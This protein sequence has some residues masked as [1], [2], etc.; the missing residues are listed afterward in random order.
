MSAAEVAELVEH[1]RL[2]VAL[3]QRV[4]RLREQRNMSEGELA[5]AAGLGVRRLDSIEAGRFDPPFDVLLALADAL[6]VKSAE[7]FGCDEAETTG[8]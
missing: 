2:L 8:S 7:L 4:R 1:D 6:G 5:G 3:G